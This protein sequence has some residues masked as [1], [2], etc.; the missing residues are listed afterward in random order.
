[1]AL[2]STLVT[3]E[4]KNAAGLEVE[5]QKQKQGDWW[6]EFHYSAEN[7]ALPY[8]MKISH[9]E[10]G[11]GSTK[12]R[13]SNIT[14]KMVNTGGLDA[15]KQKTDSVSFTIDRM[16]GNENDAGAVVKNLVANMLSFCGTTGAATTVLFDC[17]GT[18][19]SNLLSGG[20]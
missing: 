13:R 12:R 7:P 15:T 10:I 5:F 3:N 8:L 18:G 17:T 16:I 6:S 11:S 4:I 9:Q 20:I 1:M 19:A 14:F 2:A